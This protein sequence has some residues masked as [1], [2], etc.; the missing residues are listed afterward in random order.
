MSDNV[1]TGPDL[2]TYL[3]WAAERKAALP[4]VRS[5]PLLSDSVA[6]LERKC[7]ALHRLCGEVLATLKVNV[8][9]GMLTC[10]NPKGQAQF[11]DLLGSW[12]NQYTATDNKKAEG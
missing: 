5:E 8:E 4:P 1:C 9:R 11:N 7:D 12:W 2:S 6:A 10:H 3:Q